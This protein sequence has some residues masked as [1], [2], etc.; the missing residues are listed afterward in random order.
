MSRKPRPARA[1]A[2]AAFSL[3]GLCAAPGLAENSLAETSSVLKAQEFS[4]ALIGK[5]WDVA[6]RDDEATWQITLATDGSATA[7]DDSGC[8]DWRYSVR[9]DQLCIEGGYCFVVQIFPQSHP[10]K[11]VLWPDGD[12][13]AT[14][15]V[16]SP[17]KQARECRR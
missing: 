11:Y 17:A 3:T 2:I 14:P 9:R 4:K 15:L 12:P 1:L 7:V 6:F 10:G 8:E 13:M 16:L 5:T